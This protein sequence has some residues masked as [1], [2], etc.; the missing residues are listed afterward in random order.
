MLIVS[1]LLTSLTWACGPTPNAVAENLPVLT[2][3]NKPPLDPD[4]WSKATFASGCFWCVEAIF[5]SVKG[6]QE[7]V[8]GYAGG[9]TPRPTYEEVGGGGTGHAEAIEIYYDSTV[10]D[11]PA[12]LRVYFAAGDPTQVNGQGPDR[13]TQYR[14]ILFYRNATEKQLITTALADLAASGKYS[15]P[16]SVEVA[17]LDKFW[18]AEKYHQD[19]LRHNP[20]HPYVRAESL[21]RL[22]RAQAQVKD[23][24]KPD[25]LVVK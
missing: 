13:G 25:Q 16:L 20:N 23:L 1:V 8:S 11:F 2:V 5:E 3:V 21:P 19:F 9:N 14:S 4:K 22:R 15:R 6:V 24:I 10:I 7:V 18:P 12:L 17:A